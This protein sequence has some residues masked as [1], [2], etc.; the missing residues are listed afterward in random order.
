MLK[1]TKEYKD[2][3]YSIKSSLCF[4]LMI[5]IP[6][7]LLLMV[8]ISNIFN[9]FIPFVIMILLA[10][11]CLYFQIKSLN[12]L[13]NNRNLLKIKKYYKY[14]RIFYL[15]YLG[16]GLIPLFYMFDIPKEIDSLLVKLNDDK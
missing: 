10:N 3:H 4:S 12:D 13:K 9:L 6:W 5:I 2:L 8:S 16:V 1:E 11:V 14:I 15:F 7:D